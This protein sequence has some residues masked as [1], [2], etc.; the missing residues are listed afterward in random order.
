M[1]DPRQTIKVL[2]QT[3]CVH[4]HAKKKN[5]QENNFLGPYYEYKGS[6]MKYLSTCE[7]RNANT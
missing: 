6:L 4:V 7:H 3:A 1:L 2:K 5:Q